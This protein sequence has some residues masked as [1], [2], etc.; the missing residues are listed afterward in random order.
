MRTKQEFEEMQT[1]YQ[2]KISDL[3]AKLEDMERCAE[4]NKK[5]AELVSAEH[6][7]KIENLEK[8]LAE[9]GEEIERLSIAKELLL[10][11]LHY[12]RMECEKTNRQIIELDKSCGDF[13]NNLITQIEQTNKTKRLMKL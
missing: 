8:Q 1:I 13:I 12:A 9:K 5:V 4:N 2:N 6:N 7:A 10:S 3:E 11:N